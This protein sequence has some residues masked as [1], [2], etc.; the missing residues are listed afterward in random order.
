MLH[1][2]DVA[3]VIIGSI[4]GFITAVALA[5]RRQSHRAFSVLIESEP[6]SNLL[7]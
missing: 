6:G 7:F 1:E 5:P 4:A 2:T 3:S